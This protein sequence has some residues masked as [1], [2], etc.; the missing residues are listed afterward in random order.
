MAHVC[1]Y[2]RLGNKLIARLVVEVALNL[3]GENEGSE[4]QFGKIGAV[5][6]PF[7]KGDRDVKD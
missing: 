1:T 3:I 4:V 7:P 5:R 2:R 6:D